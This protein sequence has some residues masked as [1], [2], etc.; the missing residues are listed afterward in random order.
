MRHSLVI[1]M[2]L[3]C[4]SAFSEGGEEASHMYPVVNNGD[5]DSAHDKRKEVNHKHNS[6]AEED[7]HG[8]RD[9]HGDHEHGKADSR[10]EHEE[11][12]QV[13]PDKGI[14]EANESQ[15]IKLSPEAEK[16]FGLTRIRVSGP[17]VEIPKSAIVTAV[18]EINIVRY[19]NG[20]YKRVDFSEVS[21]S[22]DKIVVR[23]EDIKLGD[24]I[25]VKGL[26]FLRIAEIAAFGGAPEGH[27]H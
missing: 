7:D 25:V 8:E 24:E 23:S 1:F 9:E 26:G 16:N 22:I 4:S 12:S 10:H 19:R 20:F 11:T 6:H 27:S 5:V 13:G 21:R 3:I 15:G 14:V 17:S 2:F 18:T